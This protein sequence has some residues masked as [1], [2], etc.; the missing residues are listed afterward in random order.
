MVAFSGMDGTVFYCDFKSERHRDRIGALNITIL[1][2]AQFSIF[3]T[4]LFCKNIYRKNS[5]DLEFQTSFN[6]TKFV[7]MSS[8]FLQYLHNIGC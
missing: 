5:I 2:V 7:K 3:L 4:L 8:T 6:S 1:I